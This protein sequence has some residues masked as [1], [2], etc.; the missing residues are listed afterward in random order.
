[1]GNLARQAQFRAAPAR[2]AILQNTFAQQTVIR[3]PEIAEQENIALLTVAVLLHPMG[4]DSTGTAFAL[5]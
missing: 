5:M 4:P 2:T 1:M 3:L